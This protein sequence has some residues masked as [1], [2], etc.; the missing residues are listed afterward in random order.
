MIANPIA[1]WGLQHHG[2]WV[3]RSSDRLGYWP[4][5][6]VLVSLLYFAVSY[7]V[8]GAGFSG[9]AALGSAFGSYFM[10]IG[11]KSVWDFYRRK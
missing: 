11:L 1:L 6:S 2:P 9:K 8:T 10:F 7:A 5:A 3:T 4:L